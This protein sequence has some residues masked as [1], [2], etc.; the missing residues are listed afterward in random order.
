MIIV[1]HGSENLRLLCDRGIWL[2]RGEIRAIG[3]VAEILDR[4]EESVGARA[5]F[6]TELKDVRGAQSL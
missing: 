1:S 6:Q 2:N 4:Y 3:P 5:E